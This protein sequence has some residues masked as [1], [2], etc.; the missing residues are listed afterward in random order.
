M[1]TCGY[2]HPKVEGQ[3]TKNKFCFSQKILDFDFIKIKNIIHGL[4]DVIFNVTPCI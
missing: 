2:N 1:Q 4:Y 3:G